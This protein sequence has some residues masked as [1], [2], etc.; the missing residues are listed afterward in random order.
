MS[1]IDERI[2]RLEQLLGLETK[3]TNSAEK[4]LVKEIEEI[5][6]LKE[7][8]PR[9]E[10]RDIERDILLALKKGQ[11]TAKEL[12]FEVKKHEIC[13]QATLFRYLKR[14]LREGRIKKRR[15]GKFVL[16]ALAGHEV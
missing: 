11:K 7:E 5:R 14:L 12:L 2:K 8:Y 4:A 1:E 3:E 13:S 16:Y 9:M 10:I 15:R 6:E